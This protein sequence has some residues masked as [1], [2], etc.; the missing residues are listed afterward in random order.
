MAQFRGHSAYGAWNLAL[1]WMHDGKHLVSAGTDIDP[2]IRI[3]DSS[4]CEQVGEPC[5]GHTHHIEMIALNPTGT[6][7]A[8]ASADHQ[9]HLWRLSDRQ[10]IATFHHPSLVYCVTFS[11]DGNDILSGGSDNMMSKWTA[12]LLEN[13]LEDQDCKACFCHLLLP[14]NMTMGNA[15]S[16]HKHSSTRCMRKRGLAHC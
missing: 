16:H 12:P 15:D 1:V 13:I 8:S 2:T 14:R 5:R 7:L 11:M 6:L 3:W 4:T 9:V 10:S